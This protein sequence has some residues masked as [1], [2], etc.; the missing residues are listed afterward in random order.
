MKESEILYAAAERLRDGQFSP[1]L[2]P[3]PKCGCFVY[4]MFGG[5]FVD[6]GLSPARTNAFDRIN[7]VVGGISLWAL[8]KNGWIDASCKDDAIA[9][10]TIAADCAFEEEKAQ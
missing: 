2:N 4:H 5:A 8:E 1:R 10:L 9:A 7:E 3:A 6:D